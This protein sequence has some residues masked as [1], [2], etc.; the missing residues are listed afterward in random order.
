MVRIMLSVSRIKRVQA[1]ARWQTHQIAGSRR[2]SDPQCN[3]RSFYDFR[4]RRVA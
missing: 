3:R 1:E 4:S 2:G